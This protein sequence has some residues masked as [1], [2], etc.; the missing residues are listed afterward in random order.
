MSQY[1]Y[2]PAYGH[3]ND[4]VVY[5]NGPAPTTNAP[6]TT[7]PT[8]SPI[9][10]SPQQYANPTYA[11]PTY[12]SPT[13]A[14]PTYATPTYANPT[15]TTPTYN[16]PTEAVKSSAL[17]QSPIR[18]AEPI[19]RQPTYTTYQD[20]VQSP[21]RVSYVTTPS[22]NF[23]YEPVPVTRETIKSSG[24]SQSVHSSLAPLYTPVTYTT[25][26]YT[27]VAYTPVNYTPLPVEEKPKS[28]ANTPMSDYLSEIDRKIKDIQ[29]KYP[30]T[31]PYEDKPTVAYPSNYVPYN[32]PSYIPTYIPY[33]PGMYASQYAP[34]QPIQTPQV[35][36][37]AQTKEPETKPE[38]QKVNKLEYK[39]IKNDFGDMKMA[40][41]FVDDPNSTYNQL[42]KKLK[43]AGA[44]FTD[45]EFPPSTPSLVS[46]KDQNDIEW[47]PDD[48]VWLRPEDFYGKGKY[49]MF[50]GGVSMDDI[51][52]GE[53]GDCY[54]LSTLAAL[55]EWPHR[56]ER[57]LV[58]KEKNDQGCYAVRICDMGEW[59]EVI[60]DDFFP[61]YADDKNLSFAKGNGGE[62]WVILIEKAWAKLYGSFAKIEAGLTREALHDLT[63]APTRYFALEN[64]NDQQKD[65]L[66][67]EIIQGD[68]MDFVMTCGSYGSNDSE[69]KD[70]IFFGHAYSLI[71][72]HEVTT[73]QGK[74]KLLR[75]RNPHSKGEWTG[76]W[77]DESP[78]WEQNPAV[79]S[80]VP[81]SDKDDGTFFMSWKDF[82]GYYEDLEICK[83][84]DEYHYNS[85]RVSAAPKT[86]VYLKLVV[87][88]EGKYYITCNQQSN[89]H[90]PDSEKF[91][92]SVG[93]V[94]IVK[95]DGKGGYEFVDG[96]YKQDREIW[97]DGHLKAGEYYV[98]VNYEWF[99]QQTNDFVL[100]SYGPEDV[101]FTKIAK[102]DVPNFNERAF[103]Q[104]AYNRH[105]Q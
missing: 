42:L 35:A 36:Q 53:I 88:K 21:T 87:A 61:C 93:F 9:S 78:L 23:S 31:S 50:E 69:C 60:L 15:Y 39:A 30:T 43:A 24:L 46:G 32:V 5:V 80:Q 91:Q 100:C 102:T 54:F 26:V 14:T 82:F 95:S 34:S 37:V 59:K 29:T 12:A 67:T 13:Y 75:I 94:I 104:Q 45:N 56:I 68:K 96:R 38:E 1:S 44:K 65:K 58:A 71:S 55:A 57:L 51:K 2:N 4:N 6:T 81:W 52:Q 83:C 70:G 63:G 18:V 92:H 10:Y 90:H 103:V 8:Y 64:M 77:S 27:P 16:V 101:K 17:Y 3:P 86:T 22:K 98:A 99:N 40:K 105:V 41:D 33:K 74:E 79:K 85:L 89:R 28:S 11:N 47:S 66:W 25:P 97:T 76:A 19:Y 72:A 7:L 48:K 73:K 62:L 84:H 49:N 20:P